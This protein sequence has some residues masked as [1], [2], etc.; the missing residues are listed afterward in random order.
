MSP[1]QTLNLAD[2]PAII[3][4]Q[5]A[6]LILE[7]NNNPCPAPPAKILPRPPTPSLF[8]LIFPNSLKISSLF[9]LLSPLSQR[10]A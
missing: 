2:L 9:S 7:D 6:M 1:F 3:E 10:I 8:S 5:E 4:A